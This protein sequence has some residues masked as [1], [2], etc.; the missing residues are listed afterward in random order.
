MDGCSWLFYGYYGGEESY[1]IVERCFLI[2][3]WENEKG[4]RRL[5]L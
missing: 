5:V 2:Y 3:L 4:F 1:Y